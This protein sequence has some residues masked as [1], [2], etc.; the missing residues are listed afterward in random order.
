MYQSESCVLPDRGFFF[1]PTVFTGVSQSHRIAREE[2]FGPVLSVLTFRTPDEAVAKANN[3]PYGLSAGIWTEKGSRI[4]WMAERMQAGVVWANTFNRFDPTSPF[5]GYKESGFGREGGRHGLLPYV[6]LVVKPEA[7]R[8]RLDVRPSTALDVRKTYKLYIDGK[9][10]RSESGRSYPVLDARGALVANAVLGSRKDLR[11]AVKAARG[12]QPSW[13]S[14][15]RVQPRPDP[16]SGRRDHAGSARTQFVDELAVGGSRGSRRPRS[17]P[18]SIDGSGTR[19]G[20]DKFAQ[21]LGSANPV[22]GPYFNFTMPEPAGVVGIVAPGRR[23]A[24]RARVAVSRRRSSPATPSSCWR[25]SDGRSSSITLAEALATSDVPGGVVNM[26][27]GDAA[28]IVPWMAGHGDVDTVDLTGCERRAPH[29]AEQQAAES[30]TRVVVASAAERDWSSDRAAEPVHHRGLR[31]STRPSGTPRVPEPGPLPVLVVLDRRIAAM[32]H[33]QNEKRRITGSSHLGRTVRAMRKILAVAITGLLVRGRRRGA[34]ERAR[35]AVRRRLGARA[36]RADG[37]AAPAQPAADGLAH[38]RRPLRRE[39]VG[40]ERRRGRRGGARR[41]ARSRRSP[42]TSGARW[43]WRS[44]APCS[45]WS[46]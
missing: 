20:A 34:P 21:I 16:V 37:R 12:A 17:T 31:A 43:C 36:P 33:H 13:A 41:A 23:A 24:A 1:R 5:G 44:L 28:E 10:P 6:E 9:F 46:R 15:Q 25:A 4:L 35:R 14:A 40:H 2:I 26:L 7:R 3:T 45:S 11:D 30:V 38:R 19:A 18:R 29:D 27:T 22:D 42:P 39:L 8:C 32:K